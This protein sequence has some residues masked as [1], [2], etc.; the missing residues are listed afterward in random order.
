M[1]LRH[2]VRALVLDTDGRVLL[3][4]YETSDGTVWA[5]PGGG[6]EPDE[7]DAEAL[8]R[9]LY[10]E[11]GLT[12][13]DIGLLVWIRRHHFQLSYPG[14]DGQEEWVYLVRTEPFQPA[15]T[16]SRKEL[17]REGVREFKWWTTDRMVVSDDLFA[18]SALREIIERIL[19]DGPPEDPLEVGV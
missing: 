18:P 6:R 5:T 14:Y 3:C 10:E 2:S 8:R 12:E 11:L 13:P 4:R 9:E 1:N 17:A 7:S 15:P 16:M 19:V